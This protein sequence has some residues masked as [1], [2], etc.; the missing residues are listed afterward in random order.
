M[1]PRVKLGETKLLGGTMAL[2]EHDGAYSVNFNGQEL[3]HSKASASERLLG[4]LGMEA[5]AGGP[6]ERILIGGL[7]LGFTLRSVMETAAKDA[8][9]DVV[10]LVPEVVEWN[11][12]H[13]QS[14]NGSLLS[15][16]RVNLH[17]EDVGPM[18]RNAAE[19][20]WDVIL[21]DAD[22]GP[23]AMVADANVSLYSNTGLRAIHTALSPHGRAVFWSAGPDVRFEN[24]LKRVGFN[25]RTV[26]AKTHDGARQ[27][28]YRLYVAERDAAI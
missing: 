4:E 17:T 13:L 26:P 12:Q 27:S 19:G 28:S 1:K 22:N 14:L 20:S 25:V 24:R 10:E 3:M 15:D 7:G 2:F 5:L 11:L 6:I 21:M 8:R 23:V 18:I 16:S 9:V